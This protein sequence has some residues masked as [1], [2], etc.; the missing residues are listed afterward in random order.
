MGEERQEES[1][2]CRVMMVKGSEGY[3]FF[4]TLNFSTESILI[5]EIQ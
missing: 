2:H 3:H 1:E 4:S 5:L